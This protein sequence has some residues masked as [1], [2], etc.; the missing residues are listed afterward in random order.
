LIE[1]TYE[2]AEAIDKRTRIS[3]EELGDLYAGG[4]PQPQ[5]REG[6]KFPFT[7]WRRTAKN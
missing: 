5:Q 6:A 4:V 3:E 7:M 1:E 2:V